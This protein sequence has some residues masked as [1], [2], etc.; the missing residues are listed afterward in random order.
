[1]AFPAINETVDHFIFVE[2]T[3][4][5]NQVIRF[6]RI[7]IAAEQF[8]REYKGAFT[9]IIPKL[10]SVIERYLSSNVAY[11]EENE[12]KQLENLNKRLEKLCRI[13]YH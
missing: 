3:E 6:T 8:F 7:F 4:R 11:D 13:T 12:R 9:E 10:I 1:M 2:D 5:L